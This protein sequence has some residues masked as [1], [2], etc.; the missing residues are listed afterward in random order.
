MHLRNVQ[1]DLSVQTLS[2]PLVLALLQTDLALVDVL[3]SLPDM[4]VQTLRGPVSKRMKKWHVMEHEDV[5]FGS[6]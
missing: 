1:W 3:R 2:R 5:I 4:C 6:F